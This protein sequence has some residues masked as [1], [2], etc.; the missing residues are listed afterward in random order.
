[1][2]EMPDAA[3]HKVPRR[4][5]TSAHVGEQR[6]GLEKFRFDRTYHAASDVVLDREDV[7]K[8]AFVPIGPDVVAVRR[9]NKLGGDAHALPGPP[10]TSFKHVARTKSSS[11][12]AHVDCRIAESKA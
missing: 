4:H 8:V 7:C 12:L 3:P 11:D 1:M 2:V 5:I 6:L 10:M 9:V